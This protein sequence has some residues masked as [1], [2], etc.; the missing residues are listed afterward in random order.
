MD[1]KLFFY[2]AALILSTFCLVSFAEEP[3]EPD[4]SDVL[5]LTKAN[6][7]ETVDPDTLFLIEFYAP[8]CGHCQALG[9]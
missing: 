5:I 7:S 9:T 8:W 2:L 3:S 6:F 1:K 4:T